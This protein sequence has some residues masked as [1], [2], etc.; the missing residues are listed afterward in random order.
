[1]AEQPNTLSGGFFKWVGTELEK[2]PGYVQDAEEIAQKWAESQFDDIDTNDKIENTDFTL[3]QPKYDFTQ[4]IFP[5]DLGEVGYNGHYMVININASNFSQFNGAINGPKGAISTSTKLNNELSKVDALRSSIDNQYRS[6]SGN[7]I[8]VG[9]YAP[10]QTRRIVESIAL[11]M[12]NSVNY[13]TTNEDTPVSL[14]DLVRKSVTNTIPLAGAAVNI[15][16]TTLNFLH[17]PINPRTEVIFAN[18]NLREFRYDFL[19]SPA[20]DVESFNLQQIIKMLRYHAAPE[21]TGAQWNLE[22]LKSLL[23]IPPSE[24][25]ITFYNRGKENTVLPKINTCILRDIFI[26]Y[27][28][29]G[30]YSTFSNGHPVQVRMQMTFLETEVI[31]KLRILQGF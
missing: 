20:N 6:V 11:F 13:V 10:R 19:F 21:F 4:R 1:M 28:P 30:I 15:A 18:T 2:L 9:Y 25:D 17:K 23:W 12:P 14:T 31:H 29:T 7:P 27:A 8:G 26:D 3:T 5:S 22:A 24:F 16:E